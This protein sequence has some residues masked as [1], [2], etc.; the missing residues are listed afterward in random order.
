MKK[1]FLLLCMLGTGL[2]Y[3]Q[4]TQDEYNYLTKGYSVT[5]A[6]GL[7]VKA[8]YT[9]TS[10]GTFSLDEGGYTLA[11]SVLSLVRTADN[12]YAAAL[13]MVHDSKKDNTTYFC[14]PS[15]K[16][17]QPLWNSFLTDLRTAYGTKDKGGYEAV[18]YALAHLINQ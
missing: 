9:L 11:V 7:G 1:L 17:D 2:A 5:I 15:A 18:M 16:T 8:G 12:S 4:T 14:I 6:Q 3:S 10:K 13:V